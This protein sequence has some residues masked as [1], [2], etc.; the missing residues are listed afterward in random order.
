MHLSFLIIFQF[1]VQQVQEAR[2][3][4]QKQKE[5]AREKWNKKN[6]Y[7]ALVR[8][9]FAPRTPEKPKEVPKEPAKP[10][11]QR[12][13]QPQPIPEVSLSLHIITDHW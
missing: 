4:F 5:E 8:E 12:E 1:G 10:A 9:M 2:N 7:A 3:K 13:V 6:Q 11:P